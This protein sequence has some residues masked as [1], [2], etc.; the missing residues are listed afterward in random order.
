M[1]DITVERMVHCGRLS[2]SQPDLVAINV[3]IACLHHIINGKW[4]SRIETKMQLFEFYRLI[5]KALEP[6][7]QATVT[8][9]C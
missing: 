9:S 6:P 7:L 4:R 8:D 5:F 1:K 3:V 2:P